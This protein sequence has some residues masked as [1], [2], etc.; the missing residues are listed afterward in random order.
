MNI[1]KILRYFQVASVAEAA[2]ETNWTDIHFSTFRKSIALII[3]RA[4]RADAISVGGFSILDLR[5]FTTV[6]VTFH[7][8]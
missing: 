7:N 4:Q 5:T 8:N 6:S 3:Q 1:F 2:Y